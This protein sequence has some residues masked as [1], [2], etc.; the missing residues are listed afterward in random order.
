VPSS[1]TQND[2]R[3]WQLRKLFQL[4]PG[5]DNGLGT[6][7]IDEAGNKC[8]FKTTVQKDGKLSTSRNTNLDHLAK[9]RDGM[10]WICAT[11]TH[12]GEYF[13][14]STTHHL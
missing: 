12:Q 4:R 6:D 9:W 8:E 10:H 13:S 3:E 2:A 11:G 1:R 14:I 5:S 7:A